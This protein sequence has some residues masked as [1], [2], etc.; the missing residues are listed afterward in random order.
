MLS[1]VGAA[2]HDGRV[3]WTE[4]QRVIAAYL[5]EAPGSREPVAN[6]LGVGG[7]PG[8]RG[9]PG[10]DPSTIRFLRARVFER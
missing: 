1:P 4:A 7:L 6:R 3:P 9:G 2:R 5:V 10:A 8:E